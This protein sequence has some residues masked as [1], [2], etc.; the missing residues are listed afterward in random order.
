M[1][2][3]PSHHVV[4]DA[5]HTDD[6]NAVSDVLTDHET[7]VTALEGVQ[8]GYLVKTG[9]NIVNVTNPAGT[10]D[11]VVIPSGTRDL[12]AY[13][14]TVTYGGV[15]TYGLDTYGQ[16]RVGAAMDSTTP[17][18]FFGQSNTQTSD[19]TRWRKNGVL[20]TVVARVDAN[21]NLFAPNITPG[22][23]TNITLTSGLVWSSSLGARPQYR[24]VGD[25]VEL[26]GAVQKTSGDF[27]TSPQ[28]LGVVPAGAAPPYQTYGLG[29]AQFSAGQDHVRIEV[30]TG[31]L[32]RFYF[33]SSTYTPTW[34]SLDNFRYSRTA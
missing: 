6:H 25:C 15:R 23:W 17:A 2:T 12:N 29:G 21:G 20:G 8:G 22:A 26:R 24:I 14:S 18:E 16:L 4:G 31:G 33:A 28:D 9:G 1:A 10:S 3:I 7:R 19:L 30:Q 27:T 5:G 34:V 32:I 11:A 13:I